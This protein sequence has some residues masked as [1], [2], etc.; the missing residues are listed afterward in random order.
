MADNHLY[1]FET[2]L[3]L[4]KYKIES[5]SFDS[6]IEKTRKIF[7]VFG[8]EYINCFDK[9]V[10]N[11]MIDAYAK[12]GKASNNMTIPSYGNNMVHILLNLGGITGDEI[13]FSHEIGHAIYCMLT[14]A[15]QPSVYFEIQPFL[16]EIP[17]VLN[18]FLIIE[19]S[20]ANSKS[21][22]EKIFYTEKLIEML[23][24]NFYLSALGAIFEK[25]MYNELK[26]GGILTSELLNEL[27]I[28][29]YVAF[30]GECVENVS[31]TNR[32]WIEMPHLFNTNYLFQYSTSIVYALCIMTK[33]KVD[34]NNFIEKYIKYL[35][36]GSSKP[37]NELLL[38]ID[39]NIYD[40]DIYSYV[41]EYFAKVI[42]SYE[43][44]LI[45]SIQ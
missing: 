19:Y 38:D 26:N 36:A 11:G 2:N 37:V 39:I 40:K 8:D 29:E 5:L 21:L 9:V 34:N 44:L 3:S 12:L 17:A 13:T 1:L 18:E 27:M 41:N 42:D 35:K 33:I 4:S 6:I 31:F 20:I 30:Y 10:N 25:N 14:E 24:N 7:K 28:K 32:Q 23:I 15:S 45:S 22:H 16:H 43:R